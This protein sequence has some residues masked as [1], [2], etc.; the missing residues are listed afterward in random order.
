MY[1]QKKSGFTTP[2]TKDSYSQPFYKIWGRL[3]QMESHNPVSTTHELPDIF[4]F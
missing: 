3:S 2:L 4:Y 1:I